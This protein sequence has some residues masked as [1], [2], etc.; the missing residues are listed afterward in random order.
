MGD[1]R[2]DAKD[3]LARSKHPAAI[4]WLLRAEAADSIESLK[5]RC[6]A[7]NLLM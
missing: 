7:S 6:F 4:G 1:R 2:C 5:L 3:V